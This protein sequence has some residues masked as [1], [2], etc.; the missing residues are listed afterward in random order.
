MAFPFVGVVAKFLAPLLLSMLSH[1]GGCPGLFFEVK[2]SGFLSA[3]LFSTYDEVDLSHL[4]EISDERLYEIKSS[5]VV[6]LNGLKTIS[7]RQ[8]R[9]LTGK[10]GELH[11]DGL[12]ELDEPLVNELSSR[13]CGLSL[14][15]IKKISLNSLKKLTKSYGFISLGSI[16]ID[17]LRNLKEFFLEPEIC[18]S[19]IFNGIKKLTVKDADIFLKCRGRLLFNKMKQIDDEVIA[20]LAKSEASFNFD[21]LD[22]ITDAQAEIL[23]SFKQPVSLPGLKKTTDRQFLSFCKS[24]TPIELASLEELSERQLQMLSGANN[25]VR[26]RS[27][28][29]LPKEVIRHYRKHEVDAQEQKFDFPF[30]HSLDDEQARELSN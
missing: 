29:S 1:E 14:N 24:K 19:L 30:V 5:G 25:F 23:S 22:T 3:V 11:L 20:A 9:I 10:N 15:G 7:P 21:S 18:S 28:R 2:A 13:L 17:E 27:L 26:F 12:T 8:A 6:K 4:T 16:G